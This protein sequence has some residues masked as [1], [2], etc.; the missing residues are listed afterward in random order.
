MLMTGSLGMVASTL[1]VQWLLPLAGLAPAV[2]GLALLVLLS[3]AVI[4][5]QVPAGPVATLDRSQIGR[6][7][8][9]KAT[10]RSGA[11]RISGA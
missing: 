5:W 7:A 4:A 6:A 9:R 2:L 8:A 1:P 3:M 11:T 10:P